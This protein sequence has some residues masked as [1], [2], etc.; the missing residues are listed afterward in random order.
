[1]HN[2]GPQKKERSSMFIFI[3]VMLFTAYLLYLAV[4]YAYRIGMEEGLAKAPFRK[5]VKEDAPAEVFDY[6][7]LM[8]PTEDLVSLGSKVFTANCQAC[9][10]A[11][12]NGDGPSGANLS[13][14]PR[15][16]HDAPADWK[17]GASTLNM[18]QTLEN[19]LGQMPNFP[20]LNPRQKFAVIH[21][22]HEE[23]VGL[24]NA[25]PDTEAAIASLP[26]PS[27]GGGGVDI[28]P[29]AETRVPVKYAIMK[30]VQQQNAR[31]R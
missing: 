8:K 25:P 24:D 3:P 26:Q 15:N 23:F 17:N 29:Y 20:A 10:G 22:V 16:F 31:Q 27:A 30:L 18:F 9:H 6:R 21:Y 4:A 5:P 19:G 13:V 28:N 2:E 11:G 12:G 1:M 7:Q 14:R